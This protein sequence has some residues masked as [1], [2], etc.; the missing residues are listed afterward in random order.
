MK[1]YEFINQIEISPWDQTCLHV[2][3]VLSY[4]NKKKKILK[5]L[6]GHIKAKRTLSLHGLYYDIFYEAKIF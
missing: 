4:Y 1:L 3:S 6:R 2:K 5:T